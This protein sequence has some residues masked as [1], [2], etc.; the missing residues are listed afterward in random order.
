MKYLFIFFSHFLFFSNSVAAQDRYEYRDGDM[1]GIG[2]W[3]MGREIAYVMSHYGISWLERPEREKEERVTLLLKNMDLKPGMAVAD[4]GAGS[5][6]HAVRMSKMVG[7]GKI[8]A[9]D[10]EPKMIEYLDKRIKDEHFINIKTVLGKEQSVGLSPASIDIM[11]MVDVY[12]ELSFPYEIARSMLD[13]LK[14]GGK[15]FLIEYRAEDNS[16]PIKQVHKMTQKQ[17]VKE[18]KAAGFSFVKNMGNL[19]WQHC[20]V[21]SK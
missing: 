1:D 6:Y 10:V 8:F 20:M 4:I 18:L 5:G 12:H 7:D 2:K 13:A 16:V 14:P 9:V 19:P 15:L 21:F 3:Y 11:L 17:A